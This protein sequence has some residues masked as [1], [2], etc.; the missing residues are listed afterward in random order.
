M[1]IAAIS[2]SVR[3]AVAETDPDHGDDGGDTDDDAEHGQ[4]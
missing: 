4:G 3:C 1:I 2:G